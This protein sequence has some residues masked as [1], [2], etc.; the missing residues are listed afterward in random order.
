MALMLA[1]SGLKHVAHVIYATRHGH[2]RKFPSSRPFT[3][4]ITSNVLMM[5]NR[6]F[7]KNQGQTVDEDKRDVSKAESLQ[8]QQKLL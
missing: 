1:A 7:E 2:S 4:D 5:Q 6:A 3:L 8:N